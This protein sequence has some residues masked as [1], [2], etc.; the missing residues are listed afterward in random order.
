MADAAD[1]LLAAGTP[2]SNARARTFTRQPSALGTRHRNRSQPH[3]LR[4]SGTDGRVIRPRSQQRFVLAASFL[5][6]DL[7]LTFASV[8]AAS[9]IST[10]VARSIRRSS[11]R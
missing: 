2:L 5:V 4:N 8:P 11:R 1:R 9:T 3:A 6:R 7:W 10:G